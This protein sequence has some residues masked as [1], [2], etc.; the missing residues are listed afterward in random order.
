MLA[1]CAAE[2]EVVLAIV[3]SI[4]P[5]A[6]DS[7]AAPLAESIHRFAAVKAAA[8]RLALVPDHATLADHA[9]AAIAAAVTFEKKG[10]V[11]ACVLDVCE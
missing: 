7:G 9:L 4:P 8:R 10:L 1:A 3:S 6:L 2:D 5:A 11:R